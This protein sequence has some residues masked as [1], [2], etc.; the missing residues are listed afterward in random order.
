MTRGSA[1]RAERAV[2]SRGAWNRRLL[3]LDSA[4][5]LSGAD[6]MAGRWWCLAV[7]VLSSM[8]ACPARFKPAASSESVA[9]G[10][11]AAAIPLTAEGLAVDGGG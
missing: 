3:Y 7:A 8:L 4:I 11:A 5:E 1:R 10:L 2:A 6:K 9:D